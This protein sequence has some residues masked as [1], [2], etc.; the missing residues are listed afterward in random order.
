M[1][2]LV[3]RA[4]ILM[5]LVRHSYLSREKTSFMGDAQLDSQQHAVFVS[6]R[7]RG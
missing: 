5:S 3:L 7:C 4:V 6:C 1:K 2:F